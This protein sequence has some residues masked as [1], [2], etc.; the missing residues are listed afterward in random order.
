MPLLGA[1]LGVGILI[2]GIF[3][4]KDKWFI[5]I[6]VFGILF[7]VAVY[8]S[9]FYFSKSKFVGQGF[10]KISQMELNQLVR[11][12]EFYN[13]EHGVYPDSLQQLRTEDS[14]TSISDPVQGMN[15]KIDLHYNYHKIGDRYTV[16]S[17][18]IDG[19]PNTQDDLYPNITIRDSS[20]IGFVKVR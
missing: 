13:L 12:I 2:T 11:S 15:A 8:G 3:K 17:S 7:T 1:I 4:Y 18:G 10:V 9:L 20:K 16:F 6:G 19:F 14:L 5:A